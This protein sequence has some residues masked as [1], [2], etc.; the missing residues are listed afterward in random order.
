M[1]RRREKETE[2]MNG[3]ASPPNRIINQRRKHAWEDLQTRSLERF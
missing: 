3:E 2:E 1:K